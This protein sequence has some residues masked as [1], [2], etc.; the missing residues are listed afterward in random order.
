MSRV[1]NLL[2]IF[3]Y[4]GAVYMRAREQSNGTAYLSELSFQFPAE[5]NTIFAEVKNLATV[6][7]SI[8]IGDA[9]ALDIGVEKV[10]QF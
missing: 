2:G 10:W 7:W 4:R 6:L 9:Q 5:I 1:S 3:N 8:A